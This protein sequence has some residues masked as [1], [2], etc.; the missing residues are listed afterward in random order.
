MFIK[1]NTTALGNNQGTS[2]SSTLCS[3][4]SGVSNVSASLEVN[5]N[6]KLDAVFGDIVSGVPYLVIFFKG[7]ETSVVAFNT[8]VHGYEGKTNMIMPLISYG[9]HYVSLF[10]PVFTLV[11]YCAALHFESKFA[12]SNIT[13]NKT[14]YAVIFVN[15]AIAPC[16]LGLPSIIR[17]CCFYIPLI[18]LTNINEK[19]R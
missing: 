15:L 9:F 14:I 4:F 5:Y 17:R 16:T 2:V 10:A 6:N 1:T 12:R 8:V 18:V 11:T 19:R 7:H 3:Y 13:F